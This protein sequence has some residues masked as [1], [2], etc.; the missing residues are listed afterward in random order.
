MRNLLSTCD[1]FFTKIPIGLKGD[2]IAE[3]RVFGGDGL[4]ED[5]FVRRSGRFLF[6]GGFGLCV[7]NY[8]T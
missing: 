6:A 8:G 1:D 4:I 2:L 3:R 7:W 5:R